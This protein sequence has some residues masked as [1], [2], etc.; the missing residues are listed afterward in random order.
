MNLASKINGLIIR[1]S[2]LLSERFQK[3]MEVGME[4]GVEE[5]QRLWE[6]WLERQREVGKSDW[7][8]NPPLSRRE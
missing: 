1:D 2:L 7:D 8:D 3:G 4:K 6:E 5:N